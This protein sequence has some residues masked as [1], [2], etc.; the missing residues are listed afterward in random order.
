MYRC[1]ECNTEYETKPEYCDCGNDTFEEI[2]IE[3][4]AN[5][6]AQPEIKK[7][8]EPAAE[9]PIKQND[10]KNTSA[11]E[12]YAIITFA[13]C[14]ILSLIII[15]FVANPKQIEETAVEK[16]EVKTTATIPSIDKIWNGSTEGI[17]AYQPKTKTETKQ[18][19]T[20][21]AKKKV[22]VTQQTKTITPITTSKTTVPKTPVKQDKTISQ[23]TVSQA[24]QQTTKQTE[25]KVN[26]QE[27]ANYKIKL[28]NYIASKISFTSV[29][30]DGACSFSFKISDSGVL[31]NKS[32]SKLSDNDS[33]N[34]AVYNALRQVYSYSAPPTG[35]KNE[36]LKITVKMYNNSFEVYLD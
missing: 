33:L 23:K 19:E 7:E 24:A 5:V 4:Q 28:R 2:I 34:D 31:T 1:K 3:V 35:Y 11:I 12:P 13:I 8:P 16:N 10:Q 22:E 14:L 15:L 30:G 9:Q 25:I 26:P 21:E 29:V 17:S 18:Q 6:Q 27:L 32:P 36:T 20:T